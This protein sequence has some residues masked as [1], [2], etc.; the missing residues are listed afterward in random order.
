MFFNLQ[1]YS[2]R[3]LSSKI[4]F[5]VCFCRHSSKIGSM[6]G[7][8]IMCTLPCRLPNSHA[9]TRSKVVGTWIVLVDSYPKLRKPFTTTSFPLPFTTT[10]LL[11]P[12]WNRLGTQRVRE[13]VR[14][15]PPVKCPPVRTL[16][17]PFSALQLQPQLLLEVHQ[18]L[19]LP[20][21]PTLFL[22]L[23]IAEWPS[24]S[25]LARG[26]PSRLVHPQLLPRS[27]LLSLWLRMWTWGSS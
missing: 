3:A 6:R 21:L 17:P 24:P 12:L 18:Q 16:R 26:R 22:L 2:P 1:V 8:V 20:L 23:P 9:R 10:Q 11:P 27:R 5:L 7:T 4:F 15:W 13:K 25:C 19:L 14:G